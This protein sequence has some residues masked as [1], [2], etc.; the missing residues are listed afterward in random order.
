MRKYSFKDLLQDILSQRGM[1]Y[2]D[3]AERI[4]IHPETIQQWKNGRYPQVATLISIADELQLTTDELLGLERGESDLLRAAIRD[5]RHGGCI[6]CVYGKCMGAALKPVCTKP[7]GLI[8]PERGRR[9]WE[10]R[11][12]AAKE[13]RTDD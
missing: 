5:A 13:A 10:W 6:T 1:T 4:G 11:G 9:C 12:Y 8:S 3:L 2:M 7:H